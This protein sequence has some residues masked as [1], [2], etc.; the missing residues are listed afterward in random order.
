MPKHVSDSSE[1]RT[2][3][4][5]ILET[6]NEDLGLSLVPKQMGLKDGTV[7][8]IDGVDEENRVLCEIYSHIGVLKG[9]QPDKVAAD[10]LKMMLVGAD[11][12]DDGDTWRKLFCFGDEDASAKLKGRSWLALAA[13]QFGIEIL[14]IELPKDL[15]GSVKSAQARQE[16]TN[17]A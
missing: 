7:V 4:V 16:M 11:K 6:T 9:S 15:Q 12:G 13:R 2:A 3:E 14:T 5:V 17:R 1:Q 10:L 8:Q